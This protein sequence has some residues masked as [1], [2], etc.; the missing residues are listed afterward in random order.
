MS[1]A[2]FPVTFGPSRRRGTLHIDRE[3][4]AVRLWVAGERREGFIGHLSELADC[5]YN[6][7][8][9]E[10][11]RAELQRKALERAQRRA[12]VRP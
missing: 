4:G 10:L 1:S 12:G 2:H 11:A 5:L 7:R 3:S 6:L 9:R 8:C